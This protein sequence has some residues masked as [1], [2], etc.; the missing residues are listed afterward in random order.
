MSDKHIY[1]LWTRPP[2][3][4]AW[5]WRPLMRRV[6]QK[7]NRYGADDPV[8]GEWT[9]SLPANVQPP[10]RVHY[11]VDSDGSKIIIECL[12]DTDNVDIDKAAKW[13]T[14]KLNSIAEPVAVADD[15]ELVPIARQAVKTT[16]T[17]AQ[18]KTAMREKITVFGGLQATWAE[19]RDAANA[20][21]AANAE[22]WGEM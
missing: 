9:E 1:C 11:R 16:Y 8:T 17:E 6:I 2:A 22:D 12:L 10:H 5:Q 13:L 3:L 21:I 19:S 18:V 7:L 15:A 20:Y 14:T 4:A